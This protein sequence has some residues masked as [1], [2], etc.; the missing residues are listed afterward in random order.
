[1]LCQN[2][3]PGTL[4]VV[5]FLNK[6]SSRVSLLLYNFLMHLLTHGLIIHLKE[7]VSEP[8]LAMA[9]IIPRSKKGYNIT[10][11]NKGGYHG[12]KLRTLTA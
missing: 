9:R 1:M 10:Y 8:I 4:S 2:V 5:R 11:F 3:G 12:R 7:A 6:F